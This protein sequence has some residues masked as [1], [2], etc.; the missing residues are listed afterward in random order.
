MTEAPPI[1]ENA[2]IAQSDRG[3]GCLQSPKPKVPD[4]NLSQRE[5]LWWCKA[6][7]PFPPS[8]S[9][10][11]V[12]ALLQNFRGKNFLPDICGMSI[13]ESALELSS[14]PMRQRE[15]LLGILPDEMSKPEGIKRVHFHIGNRTGFLFKTSP[16]PPVH[17][18]ILLSSQMNC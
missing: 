12:N 13:N 3:S 4:P 15:P 1:Q 11:N 6:S 5:F 17:I 18:V 7:Q 16:P 9:E 14:V 8:Q 10:L 2:D